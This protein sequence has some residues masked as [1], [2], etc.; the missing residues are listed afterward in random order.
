[1]S[2]SSTS[3]KLKSLVAKVTSVSSSV[4]PEPVLE[5][6]ASLAPVIVIVMTM[7]SVAPLPSVAVAVIVSCAAS[8]SLSESMSVSTS[9][10]V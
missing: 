5:V 8:A 1:M 2:T 9:E 3:E 7:V 10:G 6:G 4:D